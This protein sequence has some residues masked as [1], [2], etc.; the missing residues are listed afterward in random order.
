METSDLCHGMQLRRAAQHVERVYDAALAESG[1]DER[2]L[3]V[4]LTSQ[5]TKTISRARLGWQAAQRAVENVLGADGEAMMA[6]VLGRVARLEA[7]EA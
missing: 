1:D 6:T 2:T 3:T 7:L 4:Q 5:G